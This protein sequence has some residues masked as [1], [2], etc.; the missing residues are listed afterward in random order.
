MGLT[1][2]DVRDTTWRYK[3]LSDA[4]TAV[5]LA[6]ARTECHEIAIEQSAQSDGDLMK[7]TLVEDPLYRRCMNE[8]GWYSSYRSN[9][10]ERSQ[11]AALR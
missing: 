4:G 5:S 9:V 1:A 10:N 11:P 8:R 2:C 3:P 6:Q 7:A